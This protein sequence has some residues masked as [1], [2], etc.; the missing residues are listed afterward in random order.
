MPIGLNISTAIWQSYINA[1]LD[2]LK[3]RKH[4][5]AIMDDLLLFTTT[6][7]SHFAK[8]DLLK[9]LCKNGL[10]ISP[11]KSQ[12]FKTEVQYMGNTILIKDKR[13]CVKPVRSRT[14]A[15]QKLKPP[16]TIKGC[17]GFVGMV[18]FVSI[19]C[20]ECQMPLKP[21]YN[22]TRNG[23]QFIWGEEQ[24]VAFEE[25]KS[26]LQK[27]PFLH[28]PDK[29]GRFQLYSDT[30]IFVTGSALY[31]VQNGQPKLIAYV[32]KRMPE[33]AKNYSITELETCGFAINIISFAHLLKKVDFDAVVDHLAITHT[34]KSK[35][36]PVTTRIKRLLELLSSYSFNLYNIKGKDM[37]LSDLLSRQ[38]VDDS[39]IHEIILTSFSIREVLQENYYNLGNMTEEDR[40][41]V[42]TRSQAKFSGVKEPEVHGIEKSLVLHV[43]PE[44]YKSVKPPTDKRPPIPKPRIGQSRVG[45]RRKVRVV[46]PTQMLI[47]T[48]APNVATSLPEPLIQSQ[49]TV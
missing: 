45:I 32:S 40:Y 10:K 18:N 3:S 36:E 8:L 30:S 5:Q 14:E 43:K 39:N 12:L 47:Q 13:V 24:Q 27:P 29:K 1:I 35:V 2:W 28:L 49:E 4:C 44:R 16:T 6:K 38:K 20:P 26:R 42:Q 37:I 34:M 22:L 21:I 25:I 31:Q 48:P 17:R 9:A 11:K 46:L 19:F 23:R 15:I 41:L 7:T 33:E